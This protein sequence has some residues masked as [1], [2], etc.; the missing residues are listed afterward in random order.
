MI[1][2]TTLLLEKSLKKYLVKTIDLNCN[3]FKNFFFECLCN[4][5]YWHNYFKKQKIKGIVVAH[6]VYVSG[7]PSRIAEYKNILNFF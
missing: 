6:A 2:V 4:F 5:Y 3:N 1:M 7:I